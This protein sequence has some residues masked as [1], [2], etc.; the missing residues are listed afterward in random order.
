MSNALRVARALS[1]AAALAV[2]QAGCDLLDPTKV[3]N[4]NT[5][6]E[7]LANSAEPTK[8][9]LPGVRAQ[10]ARAVASVTLLDLV[11]D[12]LEISFTNITGEMNDPHGV[13]PDGGSYNGLGGPYW[14]LQELR[15]F[16]DFVIDTIGPNDA[17]AT[18]RQL[19]EA[20]YYRGMAFLMQGENFSGLPRTTSAG[21]TS[22]QELLDLAIADFQ[23][24]LTMDPTA[25]VATAI[26]GAMARSYRA[27]GNAQQAETF[28]LQVLAE[29]PTFLNLQP[30][31]S[32]E[33]ENPIFGDN[34]T[35]QPLPRLDFLDPK[36][37]SRSAGVPLGKAEEL[38][39]I[40]AEIEMSRGNYGAAARSVA[41]AIRVALAR[42]TGTVDDPDQRF[43]AD[44][45][46]RPR[47]AA[48]LVRADPQS[49][50]RPGLVLARPGVVNVPTVSGTS[51][52]PDSV[53]ALADAEAIRH[54]FWLARQEIFYLE[55]RRLNDLGV[56]L[57]ISA[58][59]LDA[60]PVLERSIAEA[61]VQVPAYIPPS[62]AVNRFTPRSPY[63]NKTQG[64]E[65]ET[66]QIT[67]E[68]DMNRVLAREKVS[69]FGTLP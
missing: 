35:R 13:H 50:F 69:R 15:A 22:W 61:S 38:H 58:R 21:P 17:R 37:T 46:V 42:P 34:R 68:V 54:A 10:M 52:K 33:I 49:P 40:L 26:R 48:V 66:S 12:N 53:Q 36:Y 39:L 27:R 1:L 28:A 62:G 25:E 6:A 24:A 45:T 29:S 64:G 60:S 7:D 63:V 18:E 65:L 16:A 2:T 32:G 47:S 51:L 55:G 4:P 14:N 30:Y 67:I 57:P 8:A 23:A 56:R 31:S 9:L 20:R 59:E 41:D 5:T 19:G 44:L 3:S 11:T 43:N